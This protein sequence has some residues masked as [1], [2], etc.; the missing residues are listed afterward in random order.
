MPDH[1]SASLR[2]FALLAALLLA[3]VPFLSGCGSDAKSKSPEPETTS[4]FPVE[5]A[6]V[7]VGTAS[8]YVTGTASLEAADEATV[9][10]R[11]GGVVQEV[12]VEEGQFVRAGQ[13]LARL[14]DDRLQLEL[15]RAEVQLQ[16]LERVL[17]RTQAVYEKQLV[18]EEAYEQTRSEWEAQKVARDLAKLEVEY[19]T[20]RAPISGVVSA[21][22][23]KTGNMVRTNDATFRV[24]GVDPLWAVLHVPERDIRQLRVG[25]SATL[26][27]DAV[28]GETFGGTVGRINP[29]VDPATG[30]FRTVIEIR[31]PSRTARPGMFGRVRVQVDRRDSTRLIPKTAIIEEDDLTSVFVLRDT[32]ALRQTVTTG[33]TSGP[34]G[35][36]AIEITD[37]LSAGDTV[38]VSGQSA[39]RDS[40]RVEVVQ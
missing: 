23:V 35:R 39:L 4:A 11:V 17:D 7:E 38:I 9:V 13:A 29:V 2:S 3:G 25:Q 22:H 33:Y 15:D 30:T 6:A 10:A 40:A 26:Q 19:A 31:D 8:A 5:V 34:S 18:S 37:G 20:V 12:F 27:L 24:T 32:L 1:L 21:R 14:D 16:K 28:P 36:A